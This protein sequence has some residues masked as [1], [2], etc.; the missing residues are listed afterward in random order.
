MDDYTVDVHKLSYRSYVKYNRNILIM[1]F[2]TY[3]MTR[4]PKS[5]KSFPFSIFFL[6]AH[7]KYLVPLYNELISPH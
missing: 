2:E 1:S 3:S 7:P 6:N 4:E 5:R